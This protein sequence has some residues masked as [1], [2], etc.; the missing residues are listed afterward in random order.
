M[1][2]DP[3]VDVGGNLEL[4]SSLI[5]TPYEIDT[6]GAIFFI[7]EIDERTYQID[8]MLTQLRRARKFDQAAGIIIGE[9]VN[10]DPLDQNWFRSLDEV[11]DNNLGALKIPVLYGLTIGH[12]NDQLTLP[13]GVRATL[14]AD[15]GALEITENGVS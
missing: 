14:N 4:I 2:R 7:E 8:R 6:R 5:G 13:L 15:A 12:T 9:F 11:L 3:E 10:C 1:F